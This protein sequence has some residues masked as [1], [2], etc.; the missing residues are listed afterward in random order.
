MY[1]GTMNASQDEDEFR[2]SIYDA[3]DGADEEQFG[4]LS[5]R[6]LS[7]LPHDGLFMDLTA[8]AP[9]A[10][11]EAALARLDERLAGS[12]AGQAL[13]ERIASAEAE[14]FAWGLGWRG[15]LGDSALRFRYAAMVEDET[16]AWTRWAARFLA[17]P[18]A[19]DAG[20]NAGELA[21][22]LRGAGWQRFD[23]LEIAE[24]I[25]TDDPADT[26]SLEA[27]AAMLDAARE[28]ERLGP[29]ARAA[30]SYLGW[31]SAVGQGA[32]AAA[33]GAAAS[34]RLGAGSGLR[35]LRFVPVAVAA[36]RR[37]LF[38]H[39]GEP[40]AFVR[41]WSEA[42]CEACHAH[43]AAVDDLLAWRAEALRRETTKTGRA[44]IELLLR[45][46]EI[47]SEDVAQTLGA[48][49]QA[50]N[51]RL[52]AMRDSGLVQQTSEG[53]RFRRW[54]AAGQRGASGRAIS[55]VR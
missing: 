27:V 50:V 3:D 36:R 23:A 29:V 30:L 18:M 41:Q 25:P 10:A 17:A 14:A 48:T 31:A 49:Q 44:I 52:R 53:R 6:G 20:G 24:G 13:A 19:E 38:E 37:R 47:M 54:A 26:G 8:W 2:L 9:L 11:A 39:R 40:S 34:M 46:Q 51:L 4:L 32:E 22:R 15:R 16:D 28:A 55:I 5:R 45:R 12:G 21:A 43:T 42:V 33:T 35:A 7:G 1:D